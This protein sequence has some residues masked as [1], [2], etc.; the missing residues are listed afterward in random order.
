M[1]SQN[2]KELLELIKTRRCIRNFDSAKTVSREQITQILDA[3]HWA[4]SAGN[5][6]DWR[7]V[8][9]QQQAIKEELANA[10][11]GQ[12]FIAD[13]PTVIVV[14]NDLQKIEAVY[15]NRGKDMY[16]FQNTAAAIQ[17]M[18][19][20]I[21]SLGLGACWVG[22]FR[23]KSVAK[24]LGLKGHQKPVAI[25]P[26]GYPTKKPSTTDRESIDKVTVWIED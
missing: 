14:V 26:I 4:P 2:A 20:V 25:I 16:S 21:H 1:T 15:G 11:L 10:A 8:I 5:V 24:L 9:V 12:M 19:L 22:A 17:N 3:A 13:A 18:L 23:E 6:Q 7:F